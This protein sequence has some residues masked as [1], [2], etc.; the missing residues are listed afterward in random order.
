MGGTARPVDFVTEGPVPLALDVSWIHGSESAK[1][2]T[3]PDIQA[4]LY[5]EHTV[6]LR[7]NM[8]VHYEAP[9][10][11][12]LFGNARAVLID[13]GATASAEYFP[14]AGSSTGSSGTGWRS[15][16]GRL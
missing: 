10:L 7:Q 11:F 15:T 4:H 6:V 3:D 5:D 13:T 14:C 8:A 1:H 12:L 9:F 16:P 2:N